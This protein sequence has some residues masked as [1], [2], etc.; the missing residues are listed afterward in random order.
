MAAVTH[1]SLKTASLDLDLSS[2]G[3]SGIMTGRDENI[4]VLPD[5]P[6][7]DEVSLRNVSWP[8]SAACCIMV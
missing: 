5:M 3:L 8:S 6:D 2:T 1:S 4:N 7:D